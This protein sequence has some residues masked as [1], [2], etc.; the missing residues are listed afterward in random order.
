MSK[1]KICGRSLPASRLDLNC[2]SEIKNRSEYPPQQGALDMASENEIIERLA[3]IEAGQDFLC[4]SMKEL[5]FALLKVSIQ[6]EKQTQLR[7]EVD[8]LW[9]KV[10]KIGE[11]QNKC[12]IRN[13]QTQ[14]SW[15]WVFLSGLLLG[16]TM[17]F[18]NQVILK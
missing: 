8:A 4:Q 1:L 18:V 17:L 11:A 16:L 5:Q 7:I 10:D 3:R 13:L 2:S 9:K 6:E 12:P 15:M 14:V